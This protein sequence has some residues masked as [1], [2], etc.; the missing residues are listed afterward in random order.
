VL[1]DIKEQAIE[2]SLPDI[3]MKMVIDASGE[4]KKM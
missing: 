2:E 4:E 1:P 3:D